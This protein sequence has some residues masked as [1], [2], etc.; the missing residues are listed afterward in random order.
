[1]KNYKQGL[2]RIKN[3]QKYVGDADNIIFRSSWELKLLK[4]L[5]DHPDVISFSSE[6][7]IIVEEPLRKIEERIALEVSICEDLSNSILPAFDPLLVKASP[8]PS[9]SY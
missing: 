1:M 4:W 2:Y 8:D 9:P 7:L 5:D 3:R 6:E